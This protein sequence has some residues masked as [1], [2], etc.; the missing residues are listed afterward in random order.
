MCSLSYRKNFFFFFLFG[1][2]EL[3]PSVCW[4][5]PPSLLW[6]QTIYCEKDISN[7]FPTISTK[8]LPTVHISYTIMTY[9]KKLVRTKFFNTKQCPAGFSPRIMPPASLLLPKIAPLLLLLCCSHQTW[10]VPPFPQIFV[11]NPGHG[12]R[13][14][15]TSQKR[16]SFPPPE[17][18]PS[19]NIHPPLSKVLP[20][21]QC[22]G[23]QP[24]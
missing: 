23:N 19:I 6:S 8:I 9:L 4:I 22:S 15:P 24:V 20:I 18:S 3:S 21:K 10:T 11:G 1:G 16:Y 2:V 14:P 13:I 17:K 5:S 12:E 7:S